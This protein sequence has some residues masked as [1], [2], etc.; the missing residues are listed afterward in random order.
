MASFVLLGIGPVLSEKTSAQQDEEEIVDLGI[1]EYELS[2]MSCHGVDGRG[3]GPDARYLETKPADLTQI[4]MRNGGTFPADRV[5]TI[6]DGRTVVATHVPR[7]MPVWGERY[8]RPLPD[9][10]WDT[11]Q[12]ALSRIDA[13]V[14]YV[15]SL[16]ER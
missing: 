15:K 1:T 9:A 6:I 3:D 14:D 12:E 13:L 10:D 16:Q 8:R 11:E 2:C 4:T 7:E 5:A